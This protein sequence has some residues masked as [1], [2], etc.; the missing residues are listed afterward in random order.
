VA[1]ELEA[2]LDLID[3]STIRVIGRPAA[4]GPYGRQY[5]GWSGAACRS[6]V[7]LWSSI[8]GSRAPPPRYRVRVVRAGPLPPVPPAPLVAP[9]RLRRVP[10]GRDG[11]A[12]RNS[13]R[14]V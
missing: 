8:S 7:C 11:G 2:V 9:A 5:G 10:L 4:G 14:S 1:S 3:D 13:T 6:G 12:G